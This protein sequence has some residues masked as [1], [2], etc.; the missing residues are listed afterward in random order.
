MGAVFISYRREDSEGQA[1]ALY[2]EL[3]H[4]I[5]KDSVFMD[6]DSIALG[7]DFRQI[8]HKRLESCELM[9]VLIGP[10]WLN[11]KDAVGNRRLDSPTDY[12]RLEIA[13]ALA[14]EIPVTPVLLRETHMPSPDLLPDNIRDLA[15]RHGVELRH[16]RWDSDVAEMLKRLNIGSDASGPQGQASVPD[17]HSHRH[18]KGMAISVVAALF[19][20]TF[21]TW[22]WYGRNSPSGPATRNNVA[23]DRSD[24]A[25]TSPPATPS[26]LATPSQPSAAPSRRTNTPVQPTTAPSQPVLAPV[27]PRD[28]QSGGEQP[29]VSKAPS[30]ASLE[31]RIFAIESAESGLALVPLRETVRK[32][33]GQVLIWKLDDD[34][35]PD[36]RWRLVKTRHGYLIKNVESG[37]SLVPI[38]ETVENN[39]GQLVIWRVDDDGVPDQNWRLVGTK[40][41]YLIKN[42]ESDLSLVPIRETVRDS[43]GKLVI[44]RVDD[45]GVPD[46]NWVL[47]EI[48]PR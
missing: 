34:G 44:W 2:N 47:R 18:S 13:A 45:D 36:Q 16:S 7:R 21:A 23:A 43:G 11:V 10:D 38:R 27:Q 25:A 19:L 9:F 37:L 42:A 6:V 5:G 30:F 20:L 14:K 35:V 26:G 3:S 31:N 39:G 4:R 17:R 41:G 12:V 22:L 24:T 46:Q 1:R 8:L 29:Q 15:Y 28:I 33:G 32:N 40:H 48:A